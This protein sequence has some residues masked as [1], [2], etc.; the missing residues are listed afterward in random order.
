MIINSYGFCMDYDVQ[1]TRQELSELGLDNLIGS[2]M[3]KA[4]MHGYFID[5]KLYERSKAV[6]KPTM[7]EEYQ[8]EKNRKKDKERKERRITINHKKPAVNAELA[9]KW[10]QEG[11]KDEVDDRFAGL[12]NNEDFE[13]DRTSED[14]KRN[15]GGSSRGIQVEEEE[16]EG[17]ENEELF[18]EDFELL[19]THDQEN[20]NRGNDDEHD[21]MDSDNS[22]SG[23]ESEEGYLS[24][25]GR[26]EKEE[27]DRIKPKVRF[28]GIKENNKISI[29]SSKNELKKEVE[30]RKE[31][32][33]MSLGQRA[34]A[35]EKKG[36][37]KFNQSLFIPF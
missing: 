4:Y 34:K 25:K 32:R 10:E 30:K 3:L 9:E 23:E 12:F 29:P 33:T 13:I 35:L 28:Y 31:K 17:D 24:K 16:D 18:D 11:K 8:K 5:T 36:R 2:D 21:S 15:H 14:Y 22:M 20:N 26:K 6:A 19:N 7:Y 37:R 27:R 1:V